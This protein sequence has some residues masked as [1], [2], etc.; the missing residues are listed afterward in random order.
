MPYWK[1][2]APLS[3]YGLRSIRYDSSTPATLHVAT[4]YNPALR[5]G[6]FNKSGPL[7]G[8]HRV[9]APHGEQPAKRAHQG[10]LARAVAQGKRLGRL[11]GSKDGRKRRRSGYFRRRA[12]VETNGTRKYYSAMSNRCQVEVSFAPSTLFAIAEGAPV[13]CPYRKRL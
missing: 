8:P 6:K 4:N 2:A 12:K 9:G 1:V 10:G 5:S 7:V 11:P 3:D 13:Y